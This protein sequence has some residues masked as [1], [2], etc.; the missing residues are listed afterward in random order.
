MFIS[1]LT[2]QLFATG[3]VELKVKLLIVSHFLYVLIRILQCA[4]QEC[5]EAKPF[6]GASCKV[7][8]SFEHWWEKTAKVTNAVSHSN[9]HKYDRNQR[10]EWQQNRVCFDLDES[11]RRF[12]VCVSDIRYV[13]LSCHQS[14]VTIDTIALRW[15]TSI[16]PSKLND[17]NETVGIS[18][19]F[20][21]SHRALP[22][23]TASAAKSLSIVW[24]FNFA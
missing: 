23:T 5:V 1:V 7:N 17:N 9:Q 24:C 10:W 3:E 19:L 21:I 22:T 14:Y 20:I 2:V 8:D 11:H 12:E 6:I 15:T 16:S 4:Y 13:W 18:C